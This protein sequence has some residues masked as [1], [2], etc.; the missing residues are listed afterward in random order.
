[1]RSTVTHEMQQDR[2]M[3][4]FTFQEYD[5]RIAH[6]RE[7]G[8]ANWQH[9]PLPISPC[10]RLKATGEVFEWTPAFAARPDL[11]ENC[12][13][14]GNTNPAA[15]QGKRSAQ[16]TSDGRMPDIYGSPDGIA[17][18]RETPSTPPE[19]SKPSVEAPQDLH[20]F[21]DEFSTGALPDSTPQVNMAGIVLGVPPEFCK[22]YTDESNTKAALPLQHT[23]E[24]VSAAIQDAFRTR[25]YV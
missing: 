21:F 24:P 2:Q 12:D 18:A 11:C 14:T 15:W 20:F 1:M 6:L 3:G 22:D 16:L 13:A 7:L 19:K 25:Q 4:N 8:A 5:E 23:N 10:I 17:V 9:P